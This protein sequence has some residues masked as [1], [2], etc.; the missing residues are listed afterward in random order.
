MDK[1]LIQRAVAQELITDP[2]TGRRV[3]PTPTA[4]A[5]ADSNPTPETS[6]PP[7]ATSNTSNVASAIPTLLAEYA[8]RDAA[9]SVGDMVEAAAAAA[10]EELRV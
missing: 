8:L 2:P 7:G 3:P 4:A 10:A 6:L 5:S 1:L 9:A